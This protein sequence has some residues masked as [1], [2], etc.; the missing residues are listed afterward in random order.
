[1]RNNKL[2]VLNFKY[3]RRGAG[4]L[5]LLG[6]GKTMGIWPSRSGS[7]DKKGNL[8]NVVAPKTWYLRTGP[9]DPVD[10]EYDKM[11]VKSAP[12]I[13]WKERMWTM[14]APFAGET[15]SHQLIHPDGGLPGSL[16]CIV[17]QKSNAMGLFYFF[18]WIFDIHKGTVIPVDVSRIYDV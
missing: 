14:P 1:M 10:N 2:Y 18:Q 16:G 4:D 7:I 11:Y 15:F 5:I 9:E 13:G 3:N 12:G 17:P 8:I 6:A